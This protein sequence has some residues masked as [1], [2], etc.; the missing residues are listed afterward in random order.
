MIILN[1]I[2]FIIDARG[3]RHAKQTNW[4]IMAAI[5][6]GIA[7]A[8]TMKPITRK[9]HKE[10]ARRQNQGAIKSKIQLNQKSNVMETNVIQIQIIGVQR[11]PPDS[12][13]RKVQDDASTRTNVV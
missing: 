4:L 9:G 3:S 2:S 12:V 8:G 13:L 6:H 7:Q 1:A 10:R 11:H 5:Q